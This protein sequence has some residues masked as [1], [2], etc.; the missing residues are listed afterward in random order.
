M[1]F[2]NSIFKN[3]VKRPFLKFVSFSGSAA[4]W[5]NHMVAD[6][7]WENASDSLEHFLWRN[8]QYPGYIDLMPVSEADDLIVMDYGC[9]PGND[10]V[11]FAEYSKPLRL[12]GADVSPTALSV[13]KHRLS[14]HAMPVEFIQLDEDSNIIPLPDDCIDLVHSSGVLHHVKSL[15]L[16]LKEIH[17][18][19]KSGGCFQVMIY[20]YDSLWL[21]LYVAYIHQIKMQRYSNLPLLDAFKRTTDGPECPISHCYRPQDFL[22]LVSS[23][24]FSGSFKG[25]SISLHELS[26]LPQRFEAILS[27]KLAREHRDFL[28]AVSF[29]DVGHPLVDG[30]VAGIDACF[31]FRKL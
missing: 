2:W 19:L 8:S 6:D 30:H 29:N 25:A 16:A 1:S 26:L 7:V 24:G 15:N 20:N 21:H 28:S 3:F 5:S 13:A 11:G 31:E 23:V 10:L 17:R 27:Q 22:N 12:I 9:G 4:Y 18:V 14:L